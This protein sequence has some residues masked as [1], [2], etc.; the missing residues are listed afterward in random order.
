MKNRR[1]RK[2]QRH[3]L[4]GF[5]C[6]GEHIL[7]TEDRELSA[8]LLVVCS[9][10]VADVAVRIKAVIVYLYHTYRNIGAMVCDSLVVCDKIGKYKAHLN[11]T[12]ALA[13][14]PYMAVP[15]FGTHTVDNFLKR[16]NGFRL[17]NVVMLKCHNSG[18]KYLVYRTVEDVYLFNGF[19][20]E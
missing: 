13:K 11:R 7:F 1:E 12:L 2:S 6:I 20:R 10:E 9:L 14:T 16:L 18:I 5:L 17:L 3:I 8:E 15:Y 4:I 19:F